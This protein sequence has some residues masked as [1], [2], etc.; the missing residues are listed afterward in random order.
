MR[1]GV[2]FPQGELQ[3]SAA[4]I[5]QYALAVESLGYHHILLFDHVVG[6]VPEAI[7]Y[8]PRTQYTHESTFQEVFVLLGYLAALTTRIELATGVLVLPQRQAAVVAKQAA[9]V[10]CLSSGRFRLGVGS[11]WNPGEYGALGMEFHNRGQR[12]DEQVELL[13]LF[14][15]QAVVNFEGRHHVV[16]QAGINPL[17]IQR[18]I[19]IW[20]GGDTPRALQRMARLGDG[21]ICRLTSGS[22][23]ILQIGKQLSWIHEAMRTA[24]RDPGR[25]GL[26]GHMRLDKSLEALQGEIACWRD[27]G[28]THLALRTTGM[29]FTSLDQHIACLERV[30]RMI[31]SFQA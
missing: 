10:D 16:R 12:L 21:W 8:V 14:W 26:E 29:G 25:F 13:R 3:L 7:D 1:I 23:Q 31:D 30:R 11:G 5:R 9:Q 15:T 24:G 19:P 17:P 2:I 20:F 27:I 4:E 6:T 22:D 18:P 28:A